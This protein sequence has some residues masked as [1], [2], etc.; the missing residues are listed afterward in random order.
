MDRRR[1]LQTIAASAAAANTLS[2]IAQQKES[3][4]PRPNSALGTVTASKA[5]LNGRTLLCTF[6]RKGETWKVYEDLRTRDGSITFI[7]S[8]GVARV[9]TRNAEE[10]FAAEVPQ[11]LGLDIKAIGRSGPDLLAD[12]LLLRGDP[13]EMDVRSAAPPMN[14]THRQGSNGRA[15]WNTFVGTRECCATM[16]VYPG[17]NTRTYHP[18]Q[19]FKELTQEHANKRSEG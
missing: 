19:Y 3:T 10:T 13:N 11:Q 18:V 14:S 6:T 17:G 4:L 8:Q 5:N 9:L 15:N 7:S 1:F 2:T 16:P 12:K